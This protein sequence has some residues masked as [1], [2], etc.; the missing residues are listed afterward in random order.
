MEKVLEN[1]KRKGGPQYDREQ[2]TNNELDD[3]TGNGGR[4]FTP[5]GGSSGEQRVSGFSRQNPNHTEQSGENRGNIQP[6]LGQQ[7]GINDSQLKNATSSAN[8]KL[9]ITRQLVKEELTEE[10]TQLLELLN[11]TPLHKK[12]LSASYN[13]SIQQLNPE[14][15]E[16]MDLNSVLVDMIQF[17][18]ALKSVKYEDPKP[19]EGSSSS[20]NKNKGGDGDSEGN[21]D[22]YSGSANGFLFFDIIFCAIICIS[23]YMIIQYLFKSRGTRNE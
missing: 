11:S 6:V 13:G 8:T 5:A 1:G 14:N 10:Q 20:E 21:V 23:T 15:L 4:R 9:S 16:F 3:R 17:D 19:K 12:S 22:R 7:N 2:L 18:Q